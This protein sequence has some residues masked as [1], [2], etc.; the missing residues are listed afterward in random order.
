MA[1]APPRRCFQFRLRTLLLVLLVLNG[2]FGWFAYKMKQANEQRE[3]VEVVRKMGGQVFYSYSSSFFGTGKPDSSPAPAWLVS[4][5]GDDFWGNVRRVDIYHNPDITGEKL[6][7]LAGLKQL[8]S[9]A[10]FND[11]L[12]DADLA[13]PIG[14]NRLVSLNLGGNRITDAGLDQLVESSR[15][16][17]LNLWMNQITDAGLARLS[18]LTQLSEL[19]LGKTSISDAGIVHLVGLNNLQVLSLE[20]AN[21]TDAGLP[22]LKKLSR[23]RTLHLEETKISDAGAADLQKAQSVCQRS[24]NGN[25]SSVLNR[26]RSLEG[27]SGIPSEI[28]GSSVRRR[29]ETLRGFSDKASTL[30]R[31]KGINAP[32]SHCRP[33]VS[34]S[35]IRRSNHGRLFHALL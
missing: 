18:R 29:F 33:S 1:S 35:I 19:N 27:C 28:S 17:S 10:V 13:H 31:L 23:L 15:L 30:D 14:L 8:A 3:V 12:T 32:S 21:V 6:E 34:R 16:T 22:R 26:K 11:R 25:A 7:C 5:L 24:D 2:V 20:G 4:M 9:L